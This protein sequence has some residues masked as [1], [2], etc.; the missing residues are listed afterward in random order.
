VKVIQDRPRTVDVEEFLS[1]PLFAHLATASPRGPR[2]SPVW[3]L[4]DD[5]ALWIIGSRATDTFPMRIEQDSRCAVGIVDF[6]CAAGRVH[7]VGFRGRA[8][9]EPFDADRVRRLLSRYLGEDQ[10]TWDDRF[11]RTL[12]GQEAEVLVRFV[13]ETAVARD[14]SYDAPGYSQVAP[15]G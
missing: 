6:D 9:V 8:T 2:E 11:R 5:G 10:S 7:H 14:V 3:F 1:R 4:W 12:M 15:L 13:P